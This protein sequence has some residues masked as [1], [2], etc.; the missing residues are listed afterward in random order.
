[1][2]LFGVIF[3]L[4]IGILIF[5][6]LGPYTI[7]VYASISKQELTLHF[8]LAS[9]AKCFK[10]EWKIEGE[11]S[12][13]RIVFLWIPIS[14]IPFLKS[15]EN[16][17]RVSSFQKIP[18]K[19]FL[20]PVFQW[21][22]Q[23]RSMVQI[24]SLK[25]HCTIGADNPFLTGLIYGVFYAVFQKQNEAVEIQISPD[26]LCRGFSVQGEATLRFIL[27][28]ILWISMNRLKIQTRRSH[29]H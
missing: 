17:R 7:S 21:L 14:R 1:M 20:K 24:R 23:I 25:M 18:W 11:K 3:C 28:R 12:E 22:M 2:Y 9:L 29:G 26:F 10:I 15:E 4:F 13:K 6:G 5:I 16:A 19:L 27:F 8:V